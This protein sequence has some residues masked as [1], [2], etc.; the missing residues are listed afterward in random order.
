MP[1]GQAGAAEPAAQMAKA[2]LRRL[3]LSKLE[4][5]PEYYARAY[6]E[7]LGIAQRSVLPPR[8]LAL[9]QLLA[10]KVWRDEASRESFAQ[11]FARGRWHQIYPLIDVAVAEDAAHAESFAL[12]LERLVDGVDLE[13]GSGRAHGAR[14]WCSGCWPA[15]SRMRNACNSGCRI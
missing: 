3:A 12:L 2:A 8:A 6:D 13:A 7:E 9:L 1:L 4:P 14:K 15:A 5:T 11:A 10:A